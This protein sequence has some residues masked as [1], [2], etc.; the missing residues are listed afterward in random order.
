M[1]EAFLVA[2]DI[3]KSFNGQKAVSGVSF[4]INK[5]GIFRLRGPNGAG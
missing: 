1:A 2:Q 5:E 3:H 4:T